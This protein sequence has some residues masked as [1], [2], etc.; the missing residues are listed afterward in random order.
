MPRDARELAADAI[1]HLLEAATLAAE[2][3]HGG[4]PTPAELRPDL[5]HARALRAPASPL[6]RASAGAPCF[7][8]FFAPLEAP[9][10][11]A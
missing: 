7:G 11:L 5:H 2:G 9:L 1:R 4:L 8:D 10:A 3:A 6:W